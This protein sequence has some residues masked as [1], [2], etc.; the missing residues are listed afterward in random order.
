MRSDNK[1]LKKSESKKK[2]KRK[3]WPTEKESLGVEFL[4]IHSTEKWVHV[5]ERN[6][7]TSI[8]DTWGVDPSV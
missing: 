1:N 8:S 6:S 7:L 4:K 5:R 3:K 2:K